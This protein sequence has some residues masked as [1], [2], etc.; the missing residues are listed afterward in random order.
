MAIVTRT[1]VKNILNITSTTYD[2]R[3]DLLIPHVEAEF[4][5]IRGVAFDIDSN[6]DTE[7]PENA[8]LISSWMVGYLLKKSDF[9]SDAF[10]D[11]KSESIGSYSY[12]RGGAE[13]N[14]M[15]YPKSIVGG[16]ERYHNPKL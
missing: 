8:E 4:L 12:S 10:S 1:T 14:I 11:K 15:G 9:T 5:A 6:D 16:I 13:D 7:Y 3:I 2:A